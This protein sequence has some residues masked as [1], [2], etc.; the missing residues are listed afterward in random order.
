MGQLVPEYCPVLP[1]YL[2]ATID[3]QRFSQT[4]NI[5]S[6]LS[7]QAWQ[8]PHPGVSWGYAFESQ[9]R[10]VVYAT[11]NELDAELLN[12]RPRELTEDEER[13]FSQHVLARYRDADLV[14]ADAQYTT[15]EYR[16]RAGWGHARIATTVDLAVAANV[17]RLALFHHDPQHDDGLMDDLVLQARARAAQ[18]STRLEVCAA[19]EGVTLTVQ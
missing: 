4:A 5:S 9:G 15:E 12:P 3:S 13:Q 19:V 18:K 14:I 8:Q 2:A 1:Q 6:A 10:R 11:D 17:K 16:R 7:V